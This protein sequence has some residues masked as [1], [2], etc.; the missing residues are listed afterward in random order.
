MLQPSLAPVLR[1]LALAAIFLSPALPA[2]G[3]V[4]FS[5]TVTALAPSATESLPYDINNNGQVA[6]YMFVGSAKSFLYSAGAL[7]TLTAFQGSGAQAAYSGVNGIN[8]SG[9][10]AGW[11]NGQPILYSNGQT[12]S[13]G[14]LAGY[15]YGYAQS[16]NNNGQLVGTD[17]PVISDESQGH[18]YLHSAGQNVDL[19]VLPDTCTATRVTST[20]TV[21]LPV[22][23]L[24]AIACIIIHSFIPTDR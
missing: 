16:I 18:A 21:R 23:L 13:L 11:V 9:Q 6:G 3:G 24:S 20:T 4:Q 19:G 22:L 10:M 15:P 1:S 2:Q 17:T 12:T 5:Y 7:T 8:D 14:T